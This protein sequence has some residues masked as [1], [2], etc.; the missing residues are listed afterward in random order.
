MAGVAADLRIRPAAPADREAIWRILEPVIRAGETYALERD[1]SRG[2]ALGY[3]FGE[4][5][6]TF[7]A[8]QGGAVLGT[9]YLRPNQAGG[10]AHVCN[11]GYVTAANA[12]GKGIAT[13]MCRDSLRRARERGYRGMQFNFVASTNARAAALWRSLGFREI[14]RIPGG[15]LHPADGYVDAL[16][17]YRALEG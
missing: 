15:F 10:G 14:G 2:A 8:E 4:R 16:I 13:A 1:M 12:A 9:Y 11:C 5:R 3:W 6:E 7:V 17:F